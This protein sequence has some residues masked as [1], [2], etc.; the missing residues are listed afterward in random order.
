MGNVTNVTPHIP[1]SE[2]AGGGISG[3]SRGGH[4]PQKMIARGDNRSARKRDEEP[5]S[6]TEVPTTS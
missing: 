5:A 6:T 4:K 1:L 2:K 3:Q